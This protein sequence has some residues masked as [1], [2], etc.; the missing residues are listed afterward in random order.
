MQHS[1]DSPTAVR[2]KQQLSQVLDLEDDQL[3]GVPIPTLLSGGAQLFA[4]G[5]AAARDRPKETFALSKPVRRVDYFISHAWRSSRLTKYLALCRFFNKTTAMIVAAVYN[6]VWFLYVIN[7]A[8]SGV[9][10]VRHD[11]VDGTPHF[12][13]RLLRYAM[14]AGPVIVLLCAALLQHVL[15]RGATGFLDIACVPQDDEVGKAQ[16]ITRLGAVLARSERM[17]LL[18][19]EHYWRRLWCIFEVAAFCRHAERDRLVVLP[20]HVAT[21]E[22]ALLVGGIFWATLSVM[23][24]TEFATGPLYIVFMVLTNAVMIPFVIFALV[25]GRRSREALR[26]L[27]DFSIDDA[28]CHSAED[29]KA[30]IA[31]ISEWYTDTRAGET[32]PERLLEL[33]KRKFELFVRHDLAPLIERQQRNFGS[34]TGGVVALALIMHCQSNIFFPAVAPTTT[35]PQAAVNV[36]IFGLHMPLISGPTMLRAIE[37]GAAVVSILI[38]RFVPRLSSP[39]TLLRYALTAAAYLLGVALSICCTVAAGPTVRKLFTTPNQLFSPDWKFPDDGLDA[40]TRR[41][42]KQ[43]LVVTW[44]LLALWVAKIVAEVK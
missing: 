6:L 10:D 21:V 29:R 14:A 4:E 5:G 32:D 3:R 13:P 16:G 8:T 17:I 15:H 39:R 34:I 12:T 28:Q 19:D 35:L 41:Y 27:R 18:V 26:A 20:L 44:H 30:L 22:V 7:F 31:V 11:F 9:Q 43:W 23:L 1:S 38:D 40:E 24:S 37:L 2:L 42:G 25:Q 36:L 33:G